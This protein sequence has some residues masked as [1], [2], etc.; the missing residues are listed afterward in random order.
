ME[1]GRVSIERWHNLD[2]ASSTSSR[3]G[4][5]MANRES[6]GK[7]ASAKSRSVCRG[8]HLNKNDS[9]ASGYVGT[10]QGATGIIGRVAWGTLK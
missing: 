4:S 6:L 5:G 2:F 1:R 3:R 7:F 9:R 8:V 10:E